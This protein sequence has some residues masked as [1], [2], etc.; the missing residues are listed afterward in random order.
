MSG[1]EGTLP[2][3]GIC[4]IWCDFNACGLS[5]EKGDNCYYSFDRA[6]FYALPPSNGRQLF[7]WDDSDEDEVIGYVATLE[8][9]PMCVSGWRARPIESTWFRGS[10]RLIGLSL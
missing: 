2:P 1:F 9:Y 5:Q 7:I 3:N 4:K 10:R 6:P 8:E